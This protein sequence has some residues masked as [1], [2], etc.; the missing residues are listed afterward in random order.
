MVDR[1]LSTDELLHHLGWLRRLAVRLARDV[2]DGED[3]AQDTAASALQHRPAPGEGLR[4]WLATVLRNRWRAARR[5]AGRRAERERE[6]ARA[7]EL[8]DPSDSVARAELHSRVVRA[9]LE[10]REPYRAAVLQRFLEG[11][12]P[13]AIAARLGVPVA[14]IDS[15]IQRGLADLRRR[16][17]SEYGDERAQWATLALPLAAPM[18]PPV[19]P[20]AHAAPPLAKPIG[21]LLLNSKLA[22]LLVVTALAAVVAWRFESDGEGVEQRPIPALLAPGPAQGGRA[23]SA[24]FADN[25]GERAERR[26]VPSDSPLATEH[27]IVTPTAPEARVARGR[28]LDAS[29]HAL[30]G[31]PVRVRDSEVRAVSKEGGWFELETTWERGS[32]T[33]DDPRW[34][35]IY[36]GVFALD[37]ARVATL[38]VARSARFEGRVIDDA[39]RP[40]PDSF[41]QREL[42]ADFDSRFGVEVEA[43]RPASTRV[44]LDG[45]GRFEFDGP[46]LEGTALAAFSA[47]YDE[48]RVALDPGGSLGL[49]LV[50]TRASSGDVGVLRGRVLSPEGQPVGGARVALGLTSVVADKAGRFE[51]QRQRA[52]TTDRLVA[53]A[54]GFLPGEL[55][56]PLPLDEGVGGWPADVEITL[57]G[58]PLRIEG[59]VVDTAGAPVPNVHVW[60][61]DA[62]RFGLV[63]QAPLEVEALAAGVA[64]PPRALLSA[65]RLP[66]EDADDYMT[67]RTTIGPPSAVWNYVVTDA[68]GAFALGGLSARPYEL[69]LLDQRTG[70]VI[71]GPR[72]PAGER[73]VQIVLASDVTVAEFT[74]VVVGPDARPVEG[75]EVNWSV[76]ARNVSARVFG[77]RSE[78]TFTHRGE[79]AL[80]DDKGRFRF[81][82]LPRQAL[83]LSL[84][85]ADIAPEG[86]LLSRQDVERG[87]V[88]IPV[89]VRCRFRVTLRPDSELRATAVSVA[90]RKDDGSPLDVLLIRGESQTAYTNYALVDGGT[91]VL[92]V[93]SSVRTIVLLDA[94]ENVI[95]ARKVTFTPDGTTPVEF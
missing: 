67:S 30:A 32:V 60:L 89:E 37:A 42:P 86:V 68:E 88:T 66:A 6:A 26:A 70:A 8:P 52:V 4:P 57:G 10:L 75:V 11:E 63:G 80:T 55:F 82:D 33:A 27:P 56:R 18:L 22:A 7:H 69:R 61:H 19:S 87:A 93:R 48:A 76:E 16:L 65:A 25:L 41:V 3:L 17:D 47:G 14:T 62:E 24:S 94:A 40:L 72:V 90:A 51:L 53:V 54:A 31:V 44:R 83:T 2:D 13:R 85:S 46:S 50:L 81:T 34:C 21:V 39:G 15:R 23:L 9:V 28:V 49:E 64:I 36:E 12:P 59:R 5:G 79:R 71:E 77:G 91:E 1:S 38:V 74:G 45:E 92:A 58:V 43:T 20:L 95:A 78:V 84:T 29:G 73:G 35:T